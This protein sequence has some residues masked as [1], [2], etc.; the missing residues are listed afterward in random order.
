MSTRDLPSRP[1]LEQYRKQAKDLLKRW[2]A[3]DP[4]TGRKL[5]DAQFDMAHEHGFTTW[6]AFTDE[7]AKRTGAAE[8]AAIWKSAEAA[9]VA[10][11]DATLARLLGAHTKMLRNERPQ[12]S[13]FGGL[14]P[15]YKH[16]D[17]RE[18]VTREHQFENWTQCA[19]FMAEMTRADSPVAQFERAVDAVALG[20][21]TA[22]E[23]SLRENPDLIRA[24]ST[25]THHSTLLH[26]VGANGV[27]SW[28]QRP[29]KN[30]VRVAE[31]L[32]DAGAEID[33]VADM[34]N[35]GCTTFGLIA[36]SIHPKTGGVLRPLI[37]LFLARG[38]RIDE[39]GAGNA[40]QI[41][42]GC[43]AN[44]RP[45]AAMYLAEKGAPLDLEGAAGV[46]GD[47]G[48]D[49]RRLQLG[50]RVR[51]CHRCRIPPRSRR[52]PE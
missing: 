11:D 44:G 30:A 26:Y 37:D 13:W 42:N 39:R 46:G 50:M 1:H 35:G 6:K 12:S 19:A 40:H 33:A 45:E 21:P 43:L 32:L 38:V 28:R 34:Y 25:R 52:Q 48:A 41:V 3:D 2:K 7:I 22:L 16:G 51:P 36:T 31:I 17:A 8:K 15:D 23:R 47:D 9:L 10:G 24:R 27:E 20:D 4:S 49:V 5:A 14:T 29:S 18:I